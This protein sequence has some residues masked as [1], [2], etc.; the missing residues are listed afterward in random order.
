MINHKQA[1][2]LA[3]V[4]HARSFR[5]TSLLIEAL[6]VEA[7]RISIVA[8]GAKRGKARTSNLLQPFIPLQISWYGNGDLVTLTVVEAINPGLGLYGRSAICGLYI[9]ELLVKLVPKWDCCK[10]LFDAYQTAIT[11]LA[12]GE[13]ADQI[14]LRK[15]EMQLLKSLG[16]GLQLNNEVETGAKIEADKYYS[17]D[18]ILGPKL[19]NSANK[20]AV[21]GKS[22]LAMASETFNDAEILLE[23]KHLMRIVLYYH[24]GSKQLKTRELLY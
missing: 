12:K 11:N 10:Q 19:V 22:I 7:G 2:H 8:R 13:V 6:I 4:L 16:Y 15:F 21:K 5:E 14:I 17:F 20:F 24:L 3:Y 23:V 18:P 9:N 1:L